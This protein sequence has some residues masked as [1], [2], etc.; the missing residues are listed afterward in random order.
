MQHEY[1][2]S[3]GLL[4][5]DS[6]MSEMLE[7]TI[8][9]PLMSSVV[10][11]PAR[12]S[13]TPESRQ[14]LPE[15]DPGSGLSSLDSLAS[16]DPATHS[17]RTSQHSLDGDLML[18]SATLPRSGTMRNGKLYRRRPLVRRISGSGYSLW[19][20]PTVPNGGRSPKGGMSPTGMTPDGKKRQVDLQ[21][22]VRMVERCLWPTPKA[23]DWRS[24]GTDPAKVQARIDKRKNQ[25]V[26]DLPDAVSL[27]GQG[28]Y[29]T[30]LLN[31]QF[32]EWLMG[33]PEDWSALED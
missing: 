22:A 13:A 6:E 26:I 27:V 10:A 20:T 18:F 3:T 12:T 2:P 32:S 29:K 28:Q 5:S 25:G 9:P 31:P 19:P 4:F 15:A 21:H 8:S 30:G 23:R 7:S 1:S 11:S 24:G 17:L 14:G 33:F 16:Y